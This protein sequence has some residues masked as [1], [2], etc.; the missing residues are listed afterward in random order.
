MNRLITGAI[1]V[2]TLL[3]RGF[4]I[5]QGTPVNV[6]FNLTFLHD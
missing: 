4:A 6:V 2:A 1:L 5:A 3:T